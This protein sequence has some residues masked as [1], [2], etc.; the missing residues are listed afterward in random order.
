MDYIH[1]QNL[2]TPG[3]VGLVAWAEATGSFELTDVV[4]R[5]SSEKED[6]HEALDFLVSIAYLSREP[7]E[8]SYV[9]TFLAPPGRAAIPDE[10]KDFQ[11][12]YPAEYAGIKGSISHNWKRFKMHKDYRQELHKLLPAIE[13]QKKAREA[14]KKS[15]AFVPIMKNAATW[16]NQR[17]WE[18]PV[19]SFESESVSNFSQEYLGWVSQKYGSLALGNLPLTASQIKAYTIG[20]GDFTGIRQRLSP[21]NKKY[22]FEKVH[23]EYY[24][25]TI[26][27]KI[28]PY[29]RLVQLYKAAIQ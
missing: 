10:F 13:A 2:A 7:T 5:F 3:L 20:D 26:P 1:D 24:S 6:L 25:N 19:D 17:C 22:Y 11:K 14:G 27:E 28:Q 9:Y 21:D 29:E 12:A 8:K 16:I 15:G 18:M 4:D 23:S